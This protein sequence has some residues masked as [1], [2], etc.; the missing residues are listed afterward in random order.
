MI[1]RQHDTCNHHLPWCRDTGKKGQGASGRLRHQDS[2]DG[3]G[4]QRGV[5]GTECRSGQESGV[6]YI[7][8]RLRS[9]SVLLV[10]GFDIDVYMCEQ[11]CNTHY[12]GSVAR[13]DH[14]SYDHA[15]GRLSCCTWYH[16]CKDSRR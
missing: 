5:Q 6:G 4:S 1:H 13:S 10:Q 2:R 12:K 16:T 8:Y 3:L 9:E 11:T 14:R 15:L 7:S